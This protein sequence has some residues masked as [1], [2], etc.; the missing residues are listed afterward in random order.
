M[1]FTKNQNTFRWIIIATS[2]IIVSVILWKT[3]EFFQHFKHEERV[4][5]ENWSF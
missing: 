2:F 4:K 1:L 3:Y 5:M